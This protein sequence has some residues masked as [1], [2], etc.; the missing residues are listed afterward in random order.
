MNDMSALLEL[1]TYQHCLYSLTK[2]NIMSNFTMSFNNLLP[3]KR[4]PASNCTTCGMLFYLDVPDS[5][6]VV[7]LSPEPTETKYAVFGLYN[8]PK[9]EW[10]STA[11]FLYF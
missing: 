6:L 2:L 11:F 4:S 3:I 5:D 1:Q 8:N 7:K 9:R 10:W